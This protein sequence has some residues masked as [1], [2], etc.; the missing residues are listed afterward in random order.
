MNEE[1]AG[2][3]QEEGKREWK[4]CKEQ[5]NVTG[6]ADFAGGEDCELS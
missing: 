1:E 5:N 3:L 4:Y 2:I 6:K